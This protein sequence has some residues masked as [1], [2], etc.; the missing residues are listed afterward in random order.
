MCG[1]SRLLVLNELGRRA[2]V[3]VALSSLGSRAAS[4][5][6]PVSPSLV[7]GATTHR[8]RQAPG[9]DA[10]NRR[11]LPVPPFGKALGKDEAAGMETPGE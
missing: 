6:R 8:P 11:A 4:L 9:S 3:R 2:W 7:S 1:A 10:S 5:V